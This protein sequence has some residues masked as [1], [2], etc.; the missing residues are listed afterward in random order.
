[1]TS[2]IFIS[3]CCNSSV[4]HNNHT[5]FDEC[6]KCHKRLKEDEI[7]N[8]NQK[9]KDKVI[10]SMIDG[11]TTI[12]QMQYINSIVESEP[13]KYLWHYVHITPKGVLNEGYNE[14]LT[15]EDRLRNA[16]KVIIVCEHLKKRMFYDKMTKIIEIKPELRDLLFYTKN[17]V[18]KR[19]PFYPQMFFNVEL[20]FEGFHI[21]GFYVEWV[22]EIQDMQVIYLAVN[23]N[24]FTEFWGNFHYLPVD[25]YKEEVF[26]YDRKEIKTL[27]KLKED[28]RMVV[29]NILDFINHPQDMIE[30][31]HQERSDKVNIKRMKNNKHPINNKM[32]LRPHKDFIDYLSRYNERLKCDYAFQVRGHWRHFH[33]ER[34]KNKKPVWIDSF[35]KNKGK[36]LDNRPTVMTK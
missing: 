13:L 33:A 4:A 9:F 11:E 28:M 29:S 36:E 17:Q 8:L 35:V 34:Y 14:F 30:V 20:E 5:G 26:T 22:E 18:F 25:D 2:T 1:M 7:L 15:E 19:K 31:I 27:L 3:K 6:S 12:Q 10:K 24:D 23:K 16:K 21:K 32:I